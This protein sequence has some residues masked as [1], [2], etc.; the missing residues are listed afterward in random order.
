MSATIYIVVVTDRHCDDNFYVYAN[1][2]AALAR[3]RK[4]AVAAAEHYRTTPDEELTDFMEREGWLFYS[5][6][7]DAGYVCVQISKLLDVEDA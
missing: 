3:A 6:I 2:D 1:R 7:E 4:E 5:G